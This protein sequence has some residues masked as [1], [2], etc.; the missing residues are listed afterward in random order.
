MDEKAF[1]Y[2]LQGFF[3]MTEADTLSKKQVLMIKEHLN[4]VF[5]KVTGDVK[6]PLDDLAQKT[7]PAWLNPRVNFDADE[8]VCKTDKFLKQKC[9]L[10]QRERRYC[11]QTTPVHSCSLETIGFK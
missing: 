4:L 10:P 7:A 1:C 11:Q 5:T 6:K 3:E 9:S 2:W 8:P